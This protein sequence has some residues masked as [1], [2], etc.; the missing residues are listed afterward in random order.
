MADA[1]TAQ[2]IHDALASGRRPRVHDHAQQPQGPRRPARHASA[3][4]TG[5]RWCC[6]AWTSSRRSAARRS[7]RSSWG[8]D[9][10]RGRSRIRGR[11]ARAPSGAAHDGAGRSPA[12]LRR[13][14]AGRDRGAGGRRGGAGR[15]AEGRRG[16]RQPAGRSSTCSRRRGSRAVGSRSTSG[17]RGGSTT[18]RGS[19]S[20]R[21]STAGSGSAASPRGGGTTTSRASSPT[22]SSPGVGASIGLDRLLALMEEAGWLRGPRRPP[23]SW[24]RTSPGSAP[25]PRS[26][27]PRGSAPRGSAPRSSPTPIQVGKQLGYGS[28]RG[29]KLA[30]IVGP[31]E[32]RPARS[33]TSATSPPGR[34]RR[35]SPGPTWKRP[36]AR[37][38]ATPRG[39]G[40]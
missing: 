4:P 2:V 30:V 8:R 40:S 7:P 38:S 29:H 21:R 3:S 25:R 1:E 10:A 24:W 34:S 12:R 36:S 32:Q 15:S 31:D 37:R 35:R 5:R 11:D 19:S 39:D 23:R 33:S 6:G 13:A 20:R 14:R 28:A 26:G 18:T 16:D 17:W 27:W 9:R 22:A